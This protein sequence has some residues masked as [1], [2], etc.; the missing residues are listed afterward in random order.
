MTKGIFMKTRTL[1]QAGSLTAGS[2]VWVLPKPKDSSWTRKIDWYVNG[3]ITRAEIHSPAPLPAELEKILKEEEL[4]TMTHSLPDSSPLLLS[5]SLFLPNRTTVILDSSR[6]MT[7][8]ISSIKNIWESLNARSLRV[9]LPKGLSP[10][11]FLKNFT[12]PKLRLPQDE[13]PIEILL[14]VVPDRVEAH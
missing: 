14:D 13:E 5:S 4:P 2:E 3:L 12:P 9:F 8:W 6:D 11:T 10:E 1:S 7:Q